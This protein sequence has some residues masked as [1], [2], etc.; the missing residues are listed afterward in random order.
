VRECF[1]MCAQK[2]ACGDDASC[3]RC[4][5]LSSP[6]AL[7]CPPPPKSKTKHAYRQKWG[8]APSLAACCC[9]VAAAATLLIKGYPPKSHT[10]QGPPPLLTRRRPHPPPLITLSHTLHTVVVISV[11]SPSSP[12]AAMGWSRPAPAPPAPAS[13]YFSQRPRRRRGTP[14]FNPHH[15]A[16]HARAARIATADAA[17]VAASCHGRAVVRV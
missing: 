17:V 3:K 7:Q 14:T 15:A 8:R 9:F 4:V 2:R 12:P 11:S 6:P 13:T 1:V 10:R 5:V 16:A